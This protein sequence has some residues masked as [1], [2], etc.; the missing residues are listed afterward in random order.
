M[1]LFLLSLLALPLCANAA[2]ADTSPFYET[3]AYGGTS[4]LVDCIADPLPTTPKTPNTT[5]FANVYRGRVEMIVW[6][7]ACDADPDTSVLLLRVEPVPTDDTAFNPTFGGD[8]FAVRQNGV[9]YNNIDMIDTINPLSIFDGQVDNDTSFALGQNNQPYFDQD[10]AFTLIFSDFIDGPVPIEIPA[11]DQTA[12]ELDTDI[13]I[14]LEEPAHN[15]V[16]SGVG[17]LRGWAI[18]PQ[19]LE[20]VQYYIDGVLKKVLAYG[21]SR[22]DVADKYPGYPD[23]AFSG[24]ASIYAYGLQDP[25]TH[26]ITVRA[27][28]ASGDY[29]QVTHTFDVTAFHKGYFPNPE[30]MDISASTCSQDGSSVLLNNI[31]VEGIPYDVK[32]EWQVPSQQFG[33]VDIQ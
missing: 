31:K 20:R 22:P 23:A 27:I 13:L 21:G 7:E 1:N 16:V 14:T 12:P 29:N 10:A 3:A 11:Y 19:G 5:F 8:H 2:A 26:T 33:I 30:D 17:N 18:G 9:V 28:A 4:D 24:F 25:G 6:R 15:S 32:L